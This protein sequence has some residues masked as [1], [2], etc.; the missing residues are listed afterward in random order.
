MNF[1][2]DGKQRNLTIFVSV[3][4]FVCDLFCMIHDAIF[5]VYR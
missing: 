4:Y 5:I 3:K 1:L 2:G